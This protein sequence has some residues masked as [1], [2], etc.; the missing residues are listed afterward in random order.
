MPVVEGG[1]GLGDS[2][3]C[4][5]RATCA[6]I[7]GLFLKSITKFRNLEMTCVWKLRIFN[8][9]LGGLARNLIS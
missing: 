9:V 2:N 7:P 1:G 6:S 8:M 3:T 5:T 4:E